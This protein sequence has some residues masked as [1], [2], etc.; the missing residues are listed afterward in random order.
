MPGSHLQIHRTQA[1]QE[2]ETS[3]SSTQV[4]VSAGV[5]KRVKLI[6][7]QSHNGR[8]Y[9][10]QALEKAIPLYEGAK[11]YINHPPRGQELQPRDYRDRLG[12]LRGVTFGQTGLYGDLHF[13]PKHPLAEQLLWDAQH[14][15]ETIGFS[16]HAEGRGYMEE[17][18]FVVEEIIRVHSVDLVTMPASTLGL[19]EAEEEEDPTA[20]ELISLIEELKKFPAEKVRVEIKNYFL[21]LYQAIQA[22]VDATSEHD[23]TTEQELQ[24]QQQIES[25]Q[26]QLQ[27]ARQVEKHRQQRQAL[28]QRCF[29]ARLPNGTVTEVFLNALLDASDERQVTALIED[30]RKLLAAAER[31]QSRAFD[32]IQQRDFPHDPKLFADRLR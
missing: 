30:R 27:E 26:L 24:L 1:L 25:L 20:A 5:I 19:F 4:D 18:V 10:P 11:V 14:A 21:E 7:L 22:D 2:M 3:L 32:E 23:A 12:T 28:A 8:R 13:N 6:G 9:L 31:P 15:P 16:H 29:E 17:G